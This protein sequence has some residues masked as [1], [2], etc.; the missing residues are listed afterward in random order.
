MII[1]EARI[2]DIKQIQVVRNSVKENRLS[3]PGLVTDKDCEEF[4]TQRGM[5]WVCE[6]NEQIVGFA[7]V[8]LKEHNIWALFLN[9]EFEKRGIGQLLHNTMLNWY[10]EQT[11][12]T[13]WL[14]TEFNT[15]AEQ[16]YRKAGWKPVGTHGKNE[17]KFEMT[18]SDW[19]KSNSSV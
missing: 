16:F 10:F 7:I 15:R 12:E 2:N 8:D 4:I 9:P 14:G 13:V 3:N 5:G 17:I 1:R 18:Y 6:M 19:T 11:R